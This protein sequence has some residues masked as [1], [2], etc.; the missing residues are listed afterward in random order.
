MKSVPTSLSIF[1]LKYL[2][3]FCATGLE[4]VVGITTLYGLDGPGIELR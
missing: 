3:Y 1:D 2:K 4:N